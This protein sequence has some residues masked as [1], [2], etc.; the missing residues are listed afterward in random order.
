MQLGR[1]TLGK[2]LFGGADYYGAFRFFGAVFY[3][4]GLSAGNAEGLIASMNMAFG[5]GNG[6]GTA[7]EYNVVFLG[8]SIM[9]GTGSR[10]LANMPGQLDGLLTKPRRIYNMGVHGEKMSSA[11]N[12]RVARYTPT[13]VSGIPNVAFLQYGTN[14]LG[15]G[16]TGAALYANTATPFVSFLKGLG[17]KVVIC[18]LLP[19]SDGPWTA[20]MEAERL[21]Y[22][23]AVRTGAATADAVLDL[24]ANAAMGE[25]NASDPARYPDALHPSSL[26]YRFLAGAANGIY[27]GPQTYLAKLTDALR[28]PDLGASYVP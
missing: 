22:N 16:A 10:A 25:G 12:Q 7:P 26:G 18:T 1:L 13:F 6:F 8:D 17:F 24:A 27:S 14:D 20:A 23:D 21:A 4:S 9:E 28:S 3:N 19:R 11:F 5:H 2:S 15:A